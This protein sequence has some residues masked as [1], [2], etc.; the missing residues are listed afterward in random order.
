[1]AGKKKTYVLD[2]PDL[3]KEWDWA[4]NRADGIEPNQITFGSIKPVHWICDKGHTWQATPNNRSG[5]KGCPVCAGRKIVVGFNDLASRMPDVAS[6]WHPTLNDSLQPYDVT[7]RSHKNVWWKC[8][9]CGNEWK[10]SVSNRAAGK[11]CPVCGLKKQGQQKVAGIIAEKGSFADNFPDLLSEWDYQKNTDINPHTISQNSHEKVWWVCSACQYSWSTTV[12]HRTVRM[13][14]CPACSNHAVTNAN[15]VQTLRKD[16]LKAWNYEKNTSISPEQVTPGSNRKV[17]WKCEKGHEWQATVTAI[18]NGGMCPVCCGQKVLEGYNDLATTNLNLA[19][20]WHPTL[21]GDLHPNQVTAGSSRQK[22]WWL[23]PNG[24]EYQSLVADRSKNRGCPICNKERKTSFPEQTVFFYLKQKTTAISR[25][26]LDDKTEIDVY[27]PDLKVGIEYDGYYY[28]NSSSA[29]EKEGKKDSI[30]RKAGIILFRIKE[31][32]TKS[33]IIPD[34]CIIYCY[35]STDYAY[36]ADVLDQLVQK[37]FVHTGF[38]MEI[39][40]DVARDSGTIY[41]QYIESQKENSL[42]VRYP[43]IAKQ[44]HPDKN[45]FVTADKVSYASG[46]I[47]WWKGTCGHEWRASVVNRQRGNGCPI[48]R[49]LQVLAGFNDLASNYPSLCSEWHPTKNTLSPEQVT[50]GSDKKVWW[51]CPNGHEYQATVSN[52]VFGRGCPICSFDKRTASRDANRIKKIGSLA[53]THPYIASEWNQMLNGDLTPA[54]VTK[55]SD[56]KVWWTCP[57]GH[58]YESAISNRTNERGCPICAGKKI[59]NG[60]NDLATVNPQLAAEWDFTKNGDLSPHTISPYSHK[61]AWWKCSC[62]NE[63]E[64]E[65]KSRQLGTGCPICRRKKKKL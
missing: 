64:A 17:W 29:K 16:L 40:F 56:R 65:I 8:S 53:E 28:H 37:I 32:K 34:D 26:L 27:L 52:R 41:T 21:N 10:A 60:V 11:G 51:L 1:M 59:V 47:F 15:C 33:E 9:T 14:G 61:K 13:H 38:R 63:W 48:C 19:A 50:K 31:I 36:L 5:G 57:N 7:S 58:D 39:D 22:I 54:G 46:K 44:W 3:M 49:G 18:A 6:E 30:I 43:E 42:A 2:L 62:G 12:S 23:C 45:G 4:A 20:E 25:Y 55:G 24:H 35:P